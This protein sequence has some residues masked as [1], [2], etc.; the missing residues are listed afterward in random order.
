MLR[1]NLTY[2]LPCFRENLRIH[3]EDNLSNLVRPVDVGKRFGDAGKRSYRIHHGTYLVLAHELQHFI[4][5]IVV[6]HGR[7]LQR[8]MMPEHAIEIYPGRI[9]IRCS[10]EHDAPVRTKYLD[11]VIDLVAASAIDHDVEP[12]LRLPKVRVVVLLLVIVSSLRSHLQRLLHFLITSRC[13]VHIGAGSLC[14]QE[15]KLRNPTAEARDQYV[16]SRLQP[17][18]TKQCT[19][20]GKSTEWQCR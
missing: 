8:E 20:S 15:C 10:I 16:V 17:A 11:E 7:S 1:V 13:N 4:E 3:H 6:T 2:P 9:S 18:A 19:K 12:P 14:K 5:L